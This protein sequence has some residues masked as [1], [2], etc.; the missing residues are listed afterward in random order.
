MQ[1]FSTNGWIIDVPFAASAAA[2]Q[3]Q[4]SRA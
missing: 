1:D 3:Q 4:I 2:N